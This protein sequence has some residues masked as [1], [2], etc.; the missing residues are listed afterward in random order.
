MKRHLSEILA[1]LSDVE[2]A[3]QALYSARLLSDT[4]MQ[5]DTVHVTSQQNDEDKR[6]KLMAALL[7]NELNKKL[8]NNEYSV[9]ECEKLCDIFMNDK[10]VYVKRYCKAAKK[11]L[12]EWKCNSDG[13]FDH[14][15]SGK[16]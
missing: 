8:K 1:N 2:L 15:P 14:G 9:D 5:L 4:F 3:L 12:N 11:E 7:A 10:D 6:N 16:S 13:Y